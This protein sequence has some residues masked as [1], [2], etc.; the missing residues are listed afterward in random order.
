MTPGM[1]ITIR[2]TA[3]LLILLLVWW[4]WGLLHTGK[5]I[6]ETN[7]PDY[8]IA[9]RKVQKDQTVK[10]KYVRQQDGDKLAARLSAGEYMVEV[11]SPRNIVAS[12]TVTIN[13]FKTTTLKI[14]IPQSVKAEAVTDINSRSLIVGSSQMLFVD[15]DTGK[16]LRVDGSDQLTSPYID[17]SFRTVVWSDESYGLAQGSSGDLF[18]VNGGKAS[19]LDLSGKPLSFTISPDRKLYVQIGKDIYSGY[20]VNDLQKIYTAR[21][22]NTR[23]FASSHGLA[24]IG[25]VAEA[26]KSQG[27]A[28]VETVSDIGQAQ[29]YASFSASNGAWSPDGRHFTAISNHGLSRIYTADLKTSA[30]IPNSGVGATAWQDSDTVLYSVA[31][32]L[33]SVKASGAGAIKLSEAPRGEINQIVVQPDAGYAYL[34]SGSS[35]DSQIDRVAL[36]GQKADDYVYQLGL[37]L[38]VNLDE[39]YIGYINF[40]IP[41]ISLAA[42]S[43]SLK[44]ACLSA[45]KARLTRYGLDVSKLNFQFIPPA[46]QD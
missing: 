41:D 19:R 4:V 39:C 34:V 15:A 1:K 35:A 2:A 40:S 29:G 46:Q 25:L 21:S 36:K 20:S 26:D 28:Y 8:T 45:A 23:L 32:S 12:R 31:G 14:D 17:G 42:Y 24:I 18:L 11:Q 16:I 6:V 44:S 22:T 30:T 7:N 13:A 33:W 5:L 37:L 9:V 43:E 38:P 27:D 3:G 10:S